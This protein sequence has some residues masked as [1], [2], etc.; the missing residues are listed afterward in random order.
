MCMLLCIH[1]LYCTTSIITWNYYYYYTKKVVIVVSIGGM[2]VCCSVY[3]CVYFSVHMDNNIMFHGG[4]NKIVSNF[5]A[6]LCAPV[7]LL[8]VGVHP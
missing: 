7:Q 6:N 3:I 4:E 5:N 1:S 2:V 8:V